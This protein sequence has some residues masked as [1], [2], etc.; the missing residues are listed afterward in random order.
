MWINSKYMDFIKRKNKQYIYWLVLFIISLTLY[1]CGLRERPESI[2]PVYENGSVAVAEFRYME[3]PVPLEAIKT[4][5]SSEKWLYAVGVERYERDKQPGVWCVYRGE[6][7]DEFEPQPYIIYD[8]NSLVSMLVDR[9]DNCYLFFTDSGGEG[10]LLK[11]NANG[12]MLWE[13]SYLAQQL[14]GKSERLSQGLV[15]EDGRVYLYDYG[16][17][18]SIFAFETDGDLREVYTPKLDALEGIAEGRNGQ[19]YGYCITGEE[20]VFVK[21]E[22]GDANQ[23]QRYVCPVVPLQVYGGR[24]DGI[25]LSTEEGLWQYIP[26][27][28]TFQRMWR[29]DDE[30]VQID[31]TQVDY[32]FRG[33]EKVHLVCRE[34]GTGM[35]GW[36]GGK[37]VFVSV[38]NGNCQD[39]PEKEI[40]TISRS[41]FHEFY[42]FD[43]QMEELVRRYNRQSRRY[44]VVVLEQEDLTTRAAQEEFLGTI[45]MQLLR[46]EGPDIIEV[47]GL[48]VSS[49]AAK[50]A[51]EDLTDYYESSEIVRTEDILESVREA[52]NVMGEN[53]I[54]IPCFSIDTMLCRENIDLGDWT[55]LRFLE[56]VQGDGSRIYGT[57]SRQTAFKYC[58]GIRMAERFVDYENRECCFDCDEFRQIL[59]GCKEWQAEVPD[60]IKA[61]SVETL[62]KQLSN[63]N[64]RRSLEQEWLLKT[65]VISNMGNA[66]DS[67]AEGYVLGYPGWDGAENRLITMDAFVMNS[68]SQNKAGAWDFLEFLLSQETQDS[69]QWG[70]PARKNS[71]EN[72]LNES[73]RSAAY[74]STEFN[75][76]FDK[77]QNPA[78]EDFARVREIVANAVY[79]YPGTY[80]NNNPVRVILEEE[81]GMYFAG[82][83][84]L[85]ETVKKIQSRVTLYLNEL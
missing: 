50:G 73:F 61:D 80:Y 58:M 42:E 46:G 81:T 28:G 9:D 24:E 56:L 76:T 69:I 65:T 78:Q 43:S 63:L 72:Y 30:Y 8:G 32:I 14:L 66:L 71:F 70:F 13:K 55:P 54:V 85:E 74:M 3:L 15:T 29:W 44:K 12:E 21:I 45:E 23:H 11:Y 64:G 47:K 77:V 1:S 17:D 27:N 10:T 49:L 25:Y 19:I 51:F 41:S 34:W 75:Y 18:G 16:A 39:Y 36:N 20:P 40:V 83:A 7:S 82:D 33:K 2:S 38:D 67:S 26:D 48:D 79:L 84:T 52:G 5:T 59:E 4:Y 53:V 37:L 22:G 35:V 57:A 31:G 6:I 68:A 60:P 62:L